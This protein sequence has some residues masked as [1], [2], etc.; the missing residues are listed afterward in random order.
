MLAAREQAERLRRIERGGHPADPHHV[1]APV[2]RDRLVRPR[3]RHGDRDIEIALAELLEQ[4]GGAARLHVQT[5]VWPPVPESDQ[6]LPQGHADEVARQSEA[7]H[8]DSLRSMRKRDD[9]VVDREQTARLAHNSFA[10]FS[11]AHARR[12]LV[13]EVEAEQA[14]QPLDLGAHGRLGHAE[15]ARGLGE[16]AH[17]DDGKQCAQELGGDINHTGSAFSAPS[18]HRGA[19]RTRPYRY[20]G[21]TVPKIARDILI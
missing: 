20:R 4:R 5:N 9:L 13:E 21:A 17:V 10:F 14:L 18:A 2:V 11:H 7:Q 12:A 15:R 16:A 3:A 6:P 19:C 1:V 8:A